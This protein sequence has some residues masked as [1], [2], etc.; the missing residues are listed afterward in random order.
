MKKLMLIVGCTLGFSLQAGPFCP[1]PGA[2]LIESPQYFWGVDR[3]N[4]YYYTKMEKV[5]DDPTLSEM[6]RFNKLFKKKRIVRRKGK[7]KR[8]RI[9]RRRRRY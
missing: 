6:K 5:D 7:N 4:T 2:T 3:R 9:R 1:G 8:R